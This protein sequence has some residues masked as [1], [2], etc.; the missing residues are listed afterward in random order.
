MSDARERSEDERRRAIGARLVRLD[1]APA[2]AVAA[3]P[4]GFPALD[5]ALGPGGFPRSAMSELFGPPACGK[6]TL[7]LQW[8]AHMQASGLAAAWIDADHTFDAA[9]AAALGVVLDG[10]PLA[11]PESAEQ[12]LEMAGR[13]ALSGAVDAVVIDS[14]AALAPQVELDAG[15]T[16]GAGLQSRVLASGLKRLARAVAKSDAAVL[17][18]NQT[19]SRMNPSEGEAETSA[20]GPSLKLYAAVRLVLE[21]ADGRS[22]RF[23]TL[24][25][26]AAAA[27][28]EGVLGRGGAVGFARTP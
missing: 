3:I 5:Q 12:A 22:V 23:R 10:L 13:L 7:A 28:R 25:N 20:G 11:L 27:F 4:T 18:L 19:R 24:K 26:K 15:V 1:T 14:A 9:Y 17:F 6:T 8:V 21:P 2:R 16:G